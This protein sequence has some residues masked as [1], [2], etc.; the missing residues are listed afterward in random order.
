MM[1]FVSLKSITIEDYLKLLQYIRH[2]RAQILNLGFLAL[3]TYNIQLNASSG[4]KRT[5]KTF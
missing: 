4:P 2:I 1:H 5:L 3:S